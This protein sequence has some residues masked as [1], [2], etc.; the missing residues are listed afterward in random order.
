MSLT[1]LYRKYLEE[2]DPTPL[3]MALADVKSMCLDTLIQTAMGDGKDVLQ[4]T[5]YLLEFSYLEKKVGRPMKEVTVPDN[6]E[7]IQDAYTLLQER[8][9]K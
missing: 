6:S 2:Q 4:A 1:T 7:F 9:G 8:F 5:K 3:G